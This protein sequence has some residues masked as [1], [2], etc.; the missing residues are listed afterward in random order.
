MITIYGKDDC[1]W[2]DQAIGILKG[3]NHKDYKYLKLHKDITLEEF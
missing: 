1:P 3:F 2:C